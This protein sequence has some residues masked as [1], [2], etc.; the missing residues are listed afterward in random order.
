MESVKF[1]KTDGEWGIFSNFAGTPVEENGIIYKTTEH[2]FQSK[3]FKDKE[4]INAVISAPTAHLAA[5]VG[6]DRT[7]P[8]RVDW[9]I[10]KDS[11]MYDALVLKAKQHPQFKKKLIES[12]EREIIEDSPYDSYWGCG[13]DGN[14]RNQL[15]KLLMK[16]RD[17]LKKETK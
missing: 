2:Y 6:R 8:L 10:I 14:G 13:K 16:L 9:E 4:N 17:Q 3:K 1:W 12:G 5:Q 15:G 7:R 11:V